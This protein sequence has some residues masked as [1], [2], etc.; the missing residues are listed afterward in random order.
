MQLY[1]NHVLTQSALNKITATERNYELTPQ[2]HELATQ[3]Q[4]SLPNQLSLLLDPSFIL[5]DLTTP[6][7]FKEKVATLLRVRPDRYGIA[8]FLNALHQDLIAPDQPTLISLDHPARYCFTLSSSTWRRLVTYGDEHGNIN[9]PSRAIERMLKL[10]RNR[11]TSPSEEIS[12]PF[13]VDDPPVHKTMTLT[14]TTF[15]QLL[16]LAETYKLSTPKA[17]NETGLAAAAIEALVRGLI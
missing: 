15:N 14:Q 1:L 8:T 4:L 16:Q 11:P 17:R 13:P 2:A 5:Q 6:P 7:S 12:L 10:K 3:Q 9:K